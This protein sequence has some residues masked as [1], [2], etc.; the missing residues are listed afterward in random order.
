MRSLLPMWEEIG[1]GCDSRAY[2]S[3]I[4]PSKSHTSFTEEAAAALLSRPQPR[5]VDSSSSSDKHAVPIIPPEPREP[6]IRVVNVSSDESEAPFKPIA[7]NS[8]QQNKRRASTAPPI[9]SISHSKPSSSGSLSSS[10]SSD[11]DKHRL[12]HVQYL[13]HSLPLSPLPSNSPPTTSPRQMSRHTSAR[14]ML[15]CG[16]QH[17]HNCPTP[18]KYNALPHYS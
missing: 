11:K 14:G 2:P 13:R 8:N 5:V 10:R 9:T 17:Q 12:P 4:G 18:L 1:I 3:I 15:E 16:T 7:R 6:P